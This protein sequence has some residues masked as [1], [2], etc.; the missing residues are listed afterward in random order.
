MEGT[1]PG[2]AST[3]G[4]SESSLSLYLLHLPLWLRSPLF[5]FIEII[6]APRFDHDSCHMDGLWNG[7][8]T[9]DG[10]PGTIHASHLAPPDVYRMYETVPTEP[11]D[12]RF[13]WDGTRST[14]DAVSLAPSNVYTMD[15]TVPTDNTSMSLV[16]KRLD[17]LTE[18]L[19]NHEL[20]LNE[21]ETESLPSTDDTFK[22]PNKRS[23][24]SGLLTQAQNRVTQ[25]ANILAADWGHG[26]F[27][28][29]LIDVLI[30]T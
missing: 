5:K 12:R 11:W 15:E 2:L 27:H 17:A 6:I 29:C 14:I 30:C 16:Q 18:Q 25:G 28:D 7:Q 26:V 10:T 3:Y 8:F 9:W 13:A 22:V 4:T 21:L 19:E 20:R 24:H 1:S 23:N